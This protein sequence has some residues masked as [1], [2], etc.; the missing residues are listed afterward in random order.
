M[1]HKLKYFFIKVFF[2]LSILN[3]LMF[4]NMFNITV[5]EIT[6]LTKTGYPS[7]PYYPLDT[8]LS[9]YINYTSVNNIFICASWFTRIL[10]VYSLDAL[11]FVNYSLYS[12]V[13][14]I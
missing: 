14:Y 6:K 11:V 7:V 5:S 4:P 13:D 12:T 1:N 2:A 9:L 10:R 8:V 3:L